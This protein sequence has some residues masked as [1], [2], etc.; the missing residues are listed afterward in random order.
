MIIATVSSPAGNSQSCCSPAPPAA[1]SV[2]LAGDK[3]TCLLRE[4]A[5]GHGGH[6]RRPYQQQTLTD[7]LRRAP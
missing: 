4:L 1:H 2:A 3:V 7:R 6:S 5:A